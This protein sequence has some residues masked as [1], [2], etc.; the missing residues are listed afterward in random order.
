MLHTDQLVPMI[1]SPSQLS[2][3]ILGLHLAPDALL[4]GK[5][6]GRVDAVGVLPQ[7]RETVVRTVKQEKGEDGQKHHD[8]DILYNPSPIGRILGKVEEIVV[9]STAKAGIRADCQVFLSK[10][11]EAKSLIEAED[12]HLDEE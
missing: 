8:V 7:T 9:N 12:L 3:I 4:L 5:L 1:H 11:I 6:E 10:R 2:L